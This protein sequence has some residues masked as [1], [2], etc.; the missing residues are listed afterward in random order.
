MEHVSRFGAMA[1]DSGYQQWP[2]AQGFQ[3]FHHLSTV[4]YQVST[5]VHGVYIQATTTEG[6]D[7][8]PGSVPLSQFPTLTY[9]REACHMG[10][11]E[12]PGKGLVRGW[13]EMG[14]SLGMIIVAWR[15]LW[16]A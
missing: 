14:T 6:F 10:T 4:E 15:K 8:P 7:V 16:P 1:V 5:K 11:D 13:C 3:G 9:R 2:T 12:V